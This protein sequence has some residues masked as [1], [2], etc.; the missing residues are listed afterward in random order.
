M[1]E[2]GGSSQLAESLDIEATDEP[3]A[4]SRSEKCSTAEMLGAI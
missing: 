4:G 1:P 2:S 3:A